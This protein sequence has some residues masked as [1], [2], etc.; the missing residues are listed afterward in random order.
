MLDLSNGSVGVG[1]LIAGIWVVKN[2]VALAL[3]RLVT[4]TT[5]PNVTNK[6]STSEGT[7]G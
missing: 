7:V 3:F 5:E 4:Q 1:P 6:K 2:D